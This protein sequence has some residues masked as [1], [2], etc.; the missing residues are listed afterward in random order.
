MV[1]GFIPRGREEV[2]GENFLAEI[3]FEDAWEMGSK[4]H[5]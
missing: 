5:R 3:K 4:G 2:G 1:L